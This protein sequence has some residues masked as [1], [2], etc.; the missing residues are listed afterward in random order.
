LTYL[1]G[2]DLE[3]DDIQPHLL[4]NAEHNAY[5]TR[6]I[7]PRV[8]ERAAIPSTRLCHKRLS[9]AADYFAARVA[10]TVSASGND[11]KGA[12]ARW[13][14]FLRDDVTVVLVEVADES[15]AFTI[16]E[17]LNDRGLDL[18]IADLVKNYLFSLAGPSNLPMVT[19]AWTSSVAIL[20]TTGDPRVFT[21]FLRHYWSSRYGV[22]RERQL[23]KNMRQL[24]NSASQVV[25]FV[26]ELHEA[27]QLYSAILNS[28][29]EFWSTFGTE[30]RAQVE[31]LLRFGLEQNRPMLLAAMQHF[32]APELGKLI[33]ATVAWSV[34]GLVAG[35]IGGG[36]TE[37]AF[38]DAGINIRSGALKNSE[39]VFKSVISIIPSDQEFKRAFATL[40][41]NR[42]KFD[43]YYL[44]ELEIFARRQSEPEFVPNR[45]ESM[46][47]VEHIFPK[48]PNPSDWPKFARVELDDWLWRLGNLVL[49]SKTPNQRL[50]NRAFNQKKPVPAQSEF[51]LTKEVAGEPD[52]SPRAI[53]RRQS[54]LAALAVDLWPRQP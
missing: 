23:F 22:A 47:T 40:I 4:L 53:E 24:I 39:E 18:T 27:A 48:N 41:E 20:D 37:K 9:E 29:H 2:R 13:A 7:L 5:F 33:K 36:T 49:L 1:A 12:L 34:R 35:G 28:D 3:T 38:S 45:D 30:T 14:G 54:R 8:S 10:E 21:N 6:R 43:R 31:T 15:S 19:N 26:S 16:F 52:W 46:V 44:Q 25:R 17:T 42:A 32:P 50:G 51:V 11:W